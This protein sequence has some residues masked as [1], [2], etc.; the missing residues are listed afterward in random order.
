MELAF[1]SEIKEESEYVVAAHYQ[2]CSVEEK[3]WTCLYAWTVQGN[4]TGKISGSKI[5]LLQTAS[6]LKK[7]G[8][9]TIAYKQLKWRKEI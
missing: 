7:E 3:R 5:D 4:K 8:W 9:D 6:V 1:N 2:C